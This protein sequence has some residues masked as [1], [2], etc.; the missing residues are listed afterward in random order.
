MAWGFRM[1]RVTRI[2]LALSAWE[3]AIICGRFGADL[4]ERQDCDAVKGARLDRDSPLFP[5]RTG[6]V[7]VRGW[8]TGG[9]I[10]SACGY[11]LGRAVGFRGF[12][13]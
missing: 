5:V 10:V 9:S 11:G 1:E 12:Q 2:E 3:A 8:N 6:A 13:L 7:V 4:G